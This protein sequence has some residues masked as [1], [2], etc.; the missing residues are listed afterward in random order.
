MA[1][2]LVW[3]KRDLRVE[4]HA[5]LFQASKAGT[6]I[7]VYV[8][9][10]E[11]LSSAEFDASHLVFINESLEDLA[12]RLEQIGSRLTV[13]QG[14][15]PEVFDRL[16]EDLGFDA[17][18]SHQETGNAITY[19]R[20]V[21]VANWVKA[22]DVKW[23]QLRQHGVIRALSTRDGWAGKWHRQ[24][25]TP[26]T[27][28]PTYVHTL[29]LTSNSGIR[30]HGSLGLPESAKT[31]VQPGGE[32][33]AHAVLDSFLNIRSADYRTSMSSPVSAWD[34]CSRLSAHIAWGNLSVRQI[35]QATRARIDEIKK[36]ARR[37]PTEARSWAASLHAFEQRLRWHCHFIQKLEDEPELE[38]N[39]L[40]RAY[41]G[42]R[43]NAFDDAHFQAWREGQTGYP[44]VDACIRA[45]HQG[46]WVNFRMRAMVVSF[47]SYQLWLHWRPT[48]VFL[49]KHFL[50]FEPGIHF[51]QVQ[52]QS[53]VTGINAI[54]IYS[55]IKQV[56]DQDPE[57]VFI[58]RYCPEL[59]RV[60][61]QFI[62]EP[63]KMPSHVQR[64]AGCIIGKHYPAPIVEHAK[65]YRLARSRI[66]A[67]KGSEYARAEASKVYRKHG[68]R[69]SPTR[70][71][72]N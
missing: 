32:T 19:Q 21:R 64:E 24:M 65:A 33:R 13:L 43:E 69:R 25:N 20:D 4:D 7:C 15:L 1:N 67:V 72:G 18:W 53:G 14:R 58:K 34:S 51:S 55:P 57:G 42:L 52:M 28:T 16:Y 70:R 29:P 46:G 2:Q 3:F 66:Y 35:Y 41:D 44:L 22:R 9:E 31:H 5:P 63:Q 39:N 30:D 12:K 10:P 23:Y 71:T 11:L 38:F 27:I 6:C 17:L 60:P 68:S 48:A 8:Y 61:T 50:D 36:Q 47:A 26:P 54:R 37:E 62:A 45:L 49:A 40:N 56:Y 59:S